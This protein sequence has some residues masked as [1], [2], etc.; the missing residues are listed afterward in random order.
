MCENIFIFK[1]TPLWHTLSSL[2]ITFT[3]FSIVIDI[4]GANLTAHLII[5]RKATNIKKMY[6]MVVKY[7]S[8]I[9]EDE[10][11]RYE[12]IS[13]KLKERNSFVNKLR[14][15]T[16]MGQTTSHNFIGYLGRRIQNIWT[17]EDHEKYEREQEIKW[18][19]KVI[20]DKYKTLINTHRFYERT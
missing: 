14:K 9:Q 13:F 3:H 15:I 5:H 6:K 8:I 17:I 12:D 10:P 11:P 1:P 7:Y 16:T 18:Q 20:K 4:I 19:R 2:T